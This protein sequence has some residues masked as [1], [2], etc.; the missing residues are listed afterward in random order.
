MDTEFVT[1]NISKIKI[2]SI[3]VTSLV[4]LAAGV[5]LWQTQDLDSRIVI[6]HNFIFEKSLYL[7][8]FQIISRYG[9]GFIAVV[10]GILALLTYKFEELKPVRPL[11]MLIFFTFGFGSITGDILKG[12]IDRARPIA[13]LAGQIASTTP[14]GSPAFPSGHATKSM[15]LA[16]PFFLMAAG[17]DFATR[18]VKVITLT[19]AVLVCYSRIAL[20]RHYL[21]DVLGGIGIALLFVVISNWFLNRFY[22]RMKIDQARLATITKR[23]SFVFFVLALFLCMI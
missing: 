7:N 4:V 5:V 9:M 22:E 12:V 3:L 23:L 16:L 17:K 8:T 18:L 15:T 19:S 2:I 10:Y 6:G 20:Q 13:E 11:F 1:N 21:S 14:A